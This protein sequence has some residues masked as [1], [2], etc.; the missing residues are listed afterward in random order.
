VWRLSLAKKRWQ[1][2]PTRSYATAALADLRASAYDS[3]RR[4]LYVLGQI[5]TAR[6]WYKAPALRLTSIDTALG[7]SRTLAEW[8]GMAQLS[9]VSLAVSPSGS[10]VLATQSSSSNVDVFEFDAGQVLN[11]KGYASAAGQLEDNLAMPDVAWLPLLNG[12]THTI[13]KVTSAQLTAKLGILQLSDVDADGIPELLDTCPGTYN[14]T[15]GSCPS[16]VG[17]VLYATAGLTLANGVQ[18][19]A[20]SGTLP[21][22]VSAGTAPLNVGTDAKIGNIL[23]GG[24][25]KLL[26]RTVAA[27]TVLAAG[28]VQLVNGAKVLGTKTQNS[29][30]VPPLLQLSNLSFPPNQGPVQISPGGVRSLSP[31]SYGNLSVMSRGVVTLSGGDYFVTGLNVL[32]PDAVLKV[33]RERSDPPVRIYTQ[34]TFIFRGRIVDSSGKTPSI[35]IVYVGTSPAIVESGFNGTLVVPNAKL[36][37]GTTARSHVGAFF[38]KTLEVQANA[39]VY[40][41]PGYMRWLP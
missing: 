20:A 16:E 22:M 23:A 5:D 32:E 4:R 25:V 6:S 41:S 3:A 18:V 10:L 39:K 1:L 24:A 31:G 30:V 7:T 2:L 15:Q 34:S 33:N 36:T 29:K 38:A 37:L 21:L 26:D 27:G 12:T 28:A 40:Y 17:S 8:P 9:R 19:T 13:A 35:A 11:W 14:P